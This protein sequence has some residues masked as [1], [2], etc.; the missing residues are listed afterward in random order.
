MD[1]ET[2]LGPL[3]TEAA[4]QRVLEQIDTAIKGGARVSLGGKKL[5]RRGFFLEPTI[6]TDIQPDN[7]AYTQ[8]FFAPVA[9]VFRVKNEKAAI[10]LAND[11]PYGLGAT[12]ITKDVER[13]KRVARQIDSGMVFINEVTGT[14]PELPFGGVKNSGYGRELSRLGIGEFVNKKLIRVAA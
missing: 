13:G 4:L 9:M 14:A 7:P 11:S 3:C 1:P 5:D 2:S 6:L 10:D 12:V 8:E